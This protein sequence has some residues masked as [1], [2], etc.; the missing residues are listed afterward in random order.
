MIPT[1]EKEEITQDVRNL[2]DKL[3]HPKDC[4]ILQLQYQYIYLRGKCE[5]Q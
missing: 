4:G 2:V 1:Q 5:Q 3:Q